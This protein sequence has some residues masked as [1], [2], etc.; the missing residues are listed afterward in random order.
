MYSMCAFNSY[1]TSVGTDSYDIGES[2]S[3]PIYAKAIDILPDDVLLEIFDCVRSSREF[4]YI[5]WAW[6]ILVHVCRRWRQLIFAFPLRL[7]LTLLCTYRTPVKK[8]LSCWPAF[9]IIMDCYDPGEKDPSPDEE[10][11][12]VAALENSG[13]VRVVR[14]TLRGSL[15][16]KMAA[17]IQQSFPALFRFSLFSIDTDIPVLPG[18]FTGGSFPSLRDVT[19]HGIPIP[20]MSTF[21]SSGSNIV[22]LGLNNIPQTGY[23]SPADLVTC[24]AMLP[25]LKDLSIS[26]Q[27]Q[28]FLSEQ[29]QLPSETRAVLPSLSIFF[30]EG[31]SAYLEDL[32]AR[33]DAPRLRLIDVI[34]QLQDGDPVL[35]DQPEFQIPEF[36]KFISRSGLNSFPF[37][38]VQISFDDDDLLSVLCCPEYE[39]N[40]Y[41][42]AIRISSSEG[43]GWQVLDMAQVLNQTSAILSEVLELNVRGD[44]P[45]PDWHLESPGIDEI[46][47]SEVLLP[48]TAVGVLRVSRMLGE[49]VA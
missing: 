36:S 44:E 8:L 39:P 5:P 49:S 33:I 25:T 2:H 9:P 29:S 11:N 4:S 30:L 16:E 40:M 14:L 10:D 28:A 37:R 21:L 1:V 35:D 20:K 3:Y 34:Y 41:A 23:I 19:F 22:R 27:P 38:L 13:R 12:V 48:F 31:E 46:P 47:W 42:I 17:V 15:W 24:L 43:M 32:V 7:D 18:G 45:D 26:F 6:N